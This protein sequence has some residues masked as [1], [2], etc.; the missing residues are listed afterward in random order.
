MINIEGLLA[1]SSPMPTPFAPRI[2]L[3]QNARTDLQALARAH[4]TPQSLSLRARII[5]RA[6]DIDTPTNLQIGRNLG[7]TNHTVGKWRRRFVTLGL[8]GLQDA[9]RSGRP[10]TIVSSTRVQVISVASTLPKEQDRPVTRWT[11]DEI[12]A[13]VLDALPTQTLSRSSVWRILHDI[14]LKPHKSAYWLNSHDEHFD[15]KARAICQ[16]YVQAL[17][18]YQQ[19]HLII[20]CDEKTGMQ[21]LERKAPTKPAQPGRRERREHEYIRHGTRVLINS[22]AVATGHIAWTL[23]AT[24]KTADFVAHLKHVYQSL[25]PMPRYD[26]IMDNL[27]TH[28]SLA[29]CRLV[30]QWC[31]V[32]FDPKQLKTG[33]QRRVFLC[34]PSHRHVFHFTPKHGSWLNQ[35]ELFFGVLHRRF[36][37]RGSFRSVAEF[38]SRLERFL[39]D[40]NTRH[41]HPY[42]WT[43]TGE[44]LVRDTPFS[45]TRRQ[46]RRGRACFSPRLKRF[47]RL[48]YAPRPYHR[49][50]A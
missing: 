23:G 36:L 6:A 24:R 33:A 30:A 34:D 47:E 20:C 17:T 8:S 43:Y 14:D 28:W 4:S 13:T 39:Q 46:Q 37:A 27:N 38:A 48:L 26:W 25:P 15:A 1:R 22:L 18:A 2:I 29:I 9:A 11:L 10:R 45:R 31:Q 49:R 5:L 19:G 44:P 32:P 7:C 16:L 42:R 50:A 35:A 40:Y 41:A 3:S 21:V 12:V